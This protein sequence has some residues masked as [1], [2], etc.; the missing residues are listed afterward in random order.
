MFHN[1][2]VALDGSPHA[3]RAL[4]EAIE[5]AECGNARLTLL[6]SVP[7]TPSWILGGAVSAGVTFQ[8]IQAETEE[9]HRHL[10]EA[11]VA[12]VPDTIP[13]TKILTHGR[14]GERIGDQIS[15]GNHDLVVMGSRGRGEMRSLLLGSVSHEVL[16]T[17]TA[18]VLIVHEQPPEAPAVEA[19]AL[20]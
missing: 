9:Q 11:A 5:L 16:S 2:L 17:S 7:D 19:P 8:A 4:D 1:I 6:T 15:R 12:R 18:A 10:L 13:V 20:S 3:V 14:A